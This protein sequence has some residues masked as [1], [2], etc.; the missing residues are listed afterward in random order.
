MEWNGFTF[1]VFV[2]NYYYSYFASAVATAM[3]KITTPVYFK[4]QCISVTSP[5]AL[6]GIIFSEFAKRII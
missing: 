5:L 1:S 3:K 4:G 2:V 6:P